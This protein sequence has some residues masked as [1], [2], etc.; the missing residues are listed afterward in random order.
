MSNA[1]N[2]SIVDNME[3]LK[4]FGTKNPTRRLDIVFVI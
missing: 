4:Q 1:F 2:A 3:V